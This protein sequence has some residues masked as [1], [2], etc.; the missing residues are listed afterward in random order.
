MTINFLDAITRVSGA[1]EKAVP[2]DAGGLNLENDAE[3]FR[4]KLH[5]Y[6]GTLT[7]P[8]N[9]YQPLKKGVEWLIQNKTNQS[10]ILR[11]ATGAT[12]TLPAGEEAA[13]YSDGVDIKQTPGSGGGSSTDGFTQITLSDAGPTTV[14]QADFDTRAIEFVG[15]LTADQSAVFPFAA[16]GGA[17]VK[18]STTGGH[19]VR[20][21]GSSGSGVNVGS[22]QLKS[23]VSTSSSIIGDSYVEVDTIAKL[24]SLVPVVG[25]VAFVRGYYAAGDGGGGD[26]RWNSTSTATANGGTI[27]ATDAGGTGR[28]ERILTQT[29]AIQV[30]WFG[31]TQD[32]SVNDKARIRK[33]LAACPMSGGKLEFAQATYNF[34]NITIADEKLLDI[35][36]Y[37]NLKIVGHGAT[38][39]CNT[40]S[41]NP[42]LPAFLYITNPSGIEISGLNF[43]DAGG[44]RDDPAVFFFGAVGIWVQAVG[45]SGYSSGLT[46]R[47]CYAE[48]VT[49]FSQVAGTTLFRVRDI[50]IINCRSKTSVYGCVF[51]ENGDN[52]RVAGFA[53]VD[54]RRGYFAYGVV[55]HDIDISM[56]DTASAL[57]STSG[58]LIK[59]YKYDTKRIKINATM[60]GIA[61]HNRAITM[62]HQSAVADLPGHIEDIDINLTLLDLT[63]PSNIVP[64]MFS[65]YDMTD[66]NN[67]VEEFTTTNRWDRIK[68]AGN[69]GAY[70]PPSAGQ[71][72]VYMRCKQLTEGLISIHPSLSEWMLP[73]IAQ[74]N[75]FKVRSGDLDDELRTYVGNI[76]TAAPAFKIPLGAYNLNA[77]TLKVTT[78]AHDQISS[79]LVQ[80]SCYRED[81]VVG[82]VSAG[83][84]VI[85]SVENVFLTQQGNAAVP[86]FTPNGANID[87]TFTGADYSF[88]NAYA[89]MTVKNVARFR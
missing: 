5:I 75:G 25:E 4:A 56:I 29:S 86:V 21:R 30:L 63:N 68:V 58:I 64:V 47:D 20:C 83:V 1:F 51:S 45:S 11:G 38:L 40:V 32:G 48:H 17:M 27:L 53:A 18:N 19:S 73:A 35:T 15:T 59:R 60:R 44:I 69:F 52:V 23:I 77:F 14:S 81:I 49:G 2:D 13:I 9:V 67:P 84:V 43:Y 50:T 61:S 82:Y 72:A 55:D 3:A 62:E 74:F 65:S 31:I 89:R 54:A 7:A 42:S 78:Y 41:P 8:R 36:G 71:S 79:L 76:I 10:L 33:A 22:K 16:G 34:G 37:E 24:T 46:V 39:I 28:W 6:T 66:P 87:V 26:F 80:N 88:S 85:I 12:V 70:S 57:G